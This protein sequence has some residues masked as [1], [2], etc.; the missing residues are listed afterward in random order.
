MYMY[1]WINKDAHAPTYLVIMQIICIMSFK[2]IWKRFD[3]IWICTYSICLYKAYFKRI[4]L[5]L[6]FFPWTW[7]Y[8]VT[9]SCCACLYPGLVW[10]RNCQ[11]WEIFKR[12]SNYM[13]TSRQALLNK[14]CYTSQITMCQPYLI[15]SQ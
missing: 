13:V 4:I 15:W 11:T 2:I 12:N 5:I 9:V 14:H 1:S 6:T 10:G 7:I 8:C 3:I